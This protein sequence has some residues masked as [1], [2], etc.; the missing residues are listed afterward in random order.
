MSWSRRR[1]DLRL[2]ALRRRG[3]RLRNLGKRL[4][5]EGAALERRRRRVAADSVHH[6]LYQN[7]RTAADAAPEGAAVAALAEADGKVLDFCRAESERIFN[8]IVRN[9]YVVDGIVQP[10]EIL[11]DV[12]RLFE[13]V[14]RIYQPGAKH[15]LLE[16]SVE[17]ILRFIQRSSLQILVQLEQLPLD[18]KRYN[19]REAHSLSQRALSYYGLYKSVSSY[20]DHA[21]PMWFLGR[22]ALGANPLTLGLSWTLTEIATRGGRRLSQHYGRRYGLRLFHETIRIIG[23]EAASVYGGDYR[24]RDPNWIYGLELTEL[25]KALPAQRRLL[26]TLLE[27]VGSMPLRSEYDRIFLYRCLARGESGHP[28]R[29]E[30]VVTLRRDERE[31]LARRLEALVARHRDASGLVAL[32][33]WKEE[34]EGRLGAGIQVEGCE[35]TALAPGKALAPLLVSLVSYVVGHKG[36]EI[37]QARGAVEASRIAALLGPEALLEAWASLTAH[38]P[39]LFDHPSV[40]PA[41]PEGRAYIEDLA[42]LQVEVAPFES[43]TELLEEAAGAVGCRTDQ[44]IERFREAC[45]ERFRRHWAEDAPKSTVPGALAVASLE[46]LS[47]P[48]EVAFFYKRVQVRGAGTGDFFPGLRLW[49]LGTTQG[50]VTL[51]GLGQEAQ[52]HSAQIFWKAGPGQFRARTG[53][54]FLGRH[55]ILRGGDWDSE[56][57]GGRQPFSIE[58]QKRPWAS[59]G[60]FGPLL[61]VASDRVD[62]G[63]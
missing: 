51:C 44:A 58:V 33:R 31:A 59:A 7:D 25:Q 22:L 28:G 1:Q 5:W 9:G 10:R 18:V 35:D 16:T 50:S 8:K 55:C 54:A 40:R 2:T 24:H 38:P 62:S 14:A 26:R 48:E 29:F 46:L 52:P 45:E 13:G 49:L 56:A 47:P 36:M 63:N 60:E 3:R 41:A 32:C 30:A 37:E 42:R 12:G 39:M 61:R 20:W 11:T 34:V 21:R 43:G 19:L 15:P 23:T 27:E 17:D 6:E 4:Q 57:L 53:R